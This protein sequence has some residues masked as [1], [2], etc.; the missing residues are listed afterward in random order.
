MCSRDSLTDLSALK[1]FE[2][3]CLHMCLE[4][5]AGQDVNCGAQT[6][7]TGQVDKSEGEDEDANA[8]PQRRLHDRSNQKHRQESDNERKP[9]NRRTAN[10]PP[11]ASRQP[12]PRDKKHGSDETKPGAEKKKKRLIC[13]KCGGKG[14]L[15]RLCPSADDCQGVEEVETE[16][17]SDADSDLFGLYWGDDRISTINSVTE[18]KDKIRGGKALMAF[19]DSGAVDKVLPKSVCTEYPLE[20][21]SKSQSG[22]VK[23][24]RKHGSHI[25][26]YGQRRF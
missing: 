11:S 25:K 9:L 3:V 7:D 10:L 26:L 12:T 8:V 13:C 18:R 16:P 19:V 22:L 2:I 20:A 6:M 4:K 15:A 5:L 1:N 21:T 17:P 14:H 23:K 24:R